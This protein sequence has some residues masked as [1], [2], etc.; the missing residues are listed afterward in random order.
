[1]QKV[2]GIA[3][4][5]GLLPRSP[6]GAARGAARELLESDEELLR[7]RD[8]IIQINAFIYRRYCVYRVRS[9]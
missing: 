9:S 3:R 8:D 7:A 5:F 6:R 1:M 4:V 2:L